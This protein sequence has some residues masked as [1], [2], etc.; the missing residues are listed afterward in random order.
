MI[1]M[2]SKTKNYGSIYDLGQCMLAVR[3]CL[4]G[5]GVNID[6]RMHATAFS[7]VRTGERGCDHYQKGQFFLLC[8]M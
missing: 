6:A 2:S 1:D 4:L 3:H 7:T 5:H 8:K